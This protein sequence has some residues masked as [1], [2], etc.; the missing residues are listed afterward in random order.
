M[1]DKDEATRRNFDYPYTVHEVQVKPGT[2]VFD[3]YVLE[4]SFD[5]DA[6]PCVYGIL[7]PLTQ[8]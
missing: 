1:V 8:E 6:H 7:R 3:Y 2:Y 4:K 5:R